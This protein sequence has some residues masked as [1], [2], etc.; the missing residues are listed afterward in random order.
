MVGVIASN[1]GFL[2]YELY[3]IDEGW[4]GYKIGIPL[5]SIVAILNLSQ[6]VRGKN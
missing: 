1:G 4:Y 3:Q 6:A 5:F 2:E